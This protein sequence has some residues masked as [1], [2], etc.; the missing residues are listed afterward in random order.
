MKGVV[1]KVWKMLAQ[2]PDGRAFHIMYAG[3]VHAESPEPEMTKEES[4]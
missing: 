1:Q 2:K 3:E 4:C